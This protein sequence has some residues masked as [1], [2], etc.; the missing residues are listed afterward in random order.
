MAVSEAAKNRIDALAVIA[1]AASSLFITVGG[2][3]I[4]Q[5]GERLNSKD[6]RITTLEISIARA[7]EHTSEHDARAQYWISAIIELQKQERQTQIRLSRLETKPNARPD[8]F[9]GSDGN[10]L[11]QM[12]NVLRQKVEGTND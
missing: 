1:I 5:H 4:S 11:E 7:L 6:L 3:I 12:I 8:P 9:T 2:Y 10:R